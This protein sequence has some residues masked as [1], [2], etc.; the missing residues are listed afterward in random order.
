M[1]LE[2]VRV[3][4]V[5]ALLLVVVVFYVLYALLVVFLVHVQLRDLGPSHVLRGVA[6]RD[7]HFALVVSC[8]YLLLI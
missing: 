7:L 8:C 2:L 6:R 1:V 5:G 4:P 3:V